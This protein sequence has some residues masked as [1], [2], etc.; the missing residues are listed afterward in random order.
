M[1]STGSTSRKVEVDETTDI[2]NR[3]QISVV[4]R[5]VNSN[6][7]VKEAF[8]GCDDLSNDRRAQG[9][10]EYVLDVLQKYKCTEKLVAQTY[11]GAA[12]MASELN[13]V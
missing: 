1:S 3:A 6:C 4:L 13:G 12:V 2:T 5:Y 10:S 8:L 11:D 7:E 9:I